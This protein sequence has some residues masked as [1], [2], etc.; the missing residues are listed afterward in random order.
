MELKDMISEQ[1]AVLGPDGQILETSHA[2]KNKNC[3]N[4]EI[5]NVCETELICSTCM[6]S[7]FL[8]LYFLV[9]ICMCAYIC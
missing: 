6:L 8:N 2:W 5:G 9:N 1:T 4:E 7:L 3:S